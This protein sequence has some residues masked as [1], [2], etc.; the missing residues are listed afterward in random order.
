MR[1]RLEMS[2]SASPSRPRSVWEG[3]LEWSCWASGSGRQQMMPTTV[4]W[5]ASLVLVL[6]AERYQAAILGTGCPR[7][8]WRMC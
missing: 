6:G 3:T 8:A 5:Q 1:W 7:G 4:G 2:C